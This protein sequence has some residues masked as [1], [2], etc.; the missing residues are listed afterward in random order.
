MLSFQS[1]F[2]PILYKTLIKAFAS[3][4]P[5]TRPPLPFCH[6]NFLTDIKKSFAQSSNID[7]QS[8]LTHLRIKVDLHRNPILYRYVYGSSKEQIQ[9]NNPVVL[10]SKVF[11]HELRYL[12]SLSDM[13]LI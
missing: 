5:A 9:S 1:T 11:L 3:D 4:P 2:G 13:T 10:L 8:M 7:L 6:E 12:Y